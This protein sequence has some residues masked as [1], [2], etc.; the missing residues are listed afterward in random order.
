MI[1]DTHC[2]A[3]ARWYEPIDTL[4]FN[5]DR[6]GVDRAVLVQLLGSTDSSDMI[7]ACA[8]HPDR[9][10][11]IGAIDP[12]A[13][14][15][16]AAL[17][18]QIEAR[19]SGLRMRANWRSAGADPLELWR[20]VE[21]AGLRVSLVGTVA[22]F[23]DGT[24]DEVAR[25]CPSLTIVLEHLGGLARPDAGDREAA[26]PSLCALAAHANVSVKLTGLGQLV[27]RLPNLD[28]AMPPL[29]TALALAPIHAV[30]AAFGPKRLMWG[31]DF[32]PVAAREG[33]GHA[34][35]WT[36]ALVAQHWPDSVNDCFGGNAAALFRL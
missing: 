22:N 32:P 17:V 31:S 20:A 16:L 6:C 19:A 14:D 4:L 25:A 10:S 8:A 13:P 29:D 3:S 34:L 36:R 30:M 21:S 5:M 26:L 7:A 11:F 35:H 9:F 12:A 1:V 28:A 27:P 24:L 18:R 2:H 15:A 23:T 33:Y